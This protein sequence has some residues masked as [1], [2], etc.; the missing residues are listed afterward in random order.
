MTQQAQT[1]HDP[2]RV[3]EPDTLVERIVHE[4]DVD[5]A[6][7]VQELPTAGG[8][9]QTWSFI[10][11]SGRRIVVTIAG[12]AVLL[13]GVAMLVL[14]GPAIVVIPAGLA[15]LATEYAWARRWLDKAKEKAELAK[16]KATRKSSRGQQ[17]K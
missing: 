12:G 17:K 14:P 5:A 4:A 15:I 10:R 16:Q 2:L 8:F 9:R 3:D 7:T 6:A 1:N 11:R 13:A